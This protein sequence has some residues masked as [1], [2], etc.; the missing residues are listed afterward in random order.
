MNFYQVLKSIVVLLLFVLGS[1]SVFYS[2]DVFAKSLGDFFY[3]KA[4]ASAS[5]SFQPEWVNGQVS[6]IQQKETTSIDS[7][8][9]ISVRA[10][11]NQYNIL[12][13]KNEQE[14]LPIASLTKLMATIIVL[15]NYDLDKK[16]TISDAAIAQEGEQGNLKMG[17]VMSVKNLLYITLIES[18]NRAA[19]ALSEVVGPEKF[20]GL[21][22]KKAKEVGLANTHFEDSTGLSEKSYS[23]A[24]DLVELS[25]YLFDN[26]PLF[27]EIVNLKEFDLYV[28]GKLHHKLVSTNKFLGEITDVVGGKTGWTIFSKGCFMVI[29]Q[30]PGSHSYFVNVILGANDRFLEMQKLID[31]VNINSN[32]HNSY[33]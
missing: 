13:S 7:E 8:S 33:L 20:I 18:S 1:A 3:Q 29:Q 32:D 2:V 10:Q 11:D 31:W 25:I 24:E 19:F 6:A 22:N 27:R 14:R 16:V 23:S 28:N 12:F 4:A 21:M 5:Y 9:F 15:D 17:E 30:T 26:Y